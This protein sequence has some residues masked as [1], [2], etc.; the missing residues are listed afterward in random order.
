MD[1]PVYHYFQD[2]SK[3]SFGADEFLFVEL[4]ESMSLVDALRV[5]LI[6]TEVSSMKI[7]G[8]L[9]VC[10]SHISYMIRVDPNRQDPRD[11]V[12]ALHDAHARFPGAESSILETEIIEIPVYYDDPWT[13]EVL[14][15]FRQR[16]QSPTETDIAYC[17]RINGFSTIRDFISAHSGSPF[18][19]TFPCFIPGNAECFQLVP[20]K[21][22]IQ[23]PK[24][25]S[26]RT[27]TPAR[28]VGHGGAFTTV[29]PTRS[30]GGYQ[31]I[32]R[33]P[34]PVF[35]MTQTNPGFEKSI[36][37]A[38]P[39]TIFKY[40]PIDYDEYFETRASVECGQY[41]YR[42][43]PVHFNYAEFVQDIDGYN[44]RLMEELS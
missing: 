37:L 11:L 3:L 16:H 19:A 40:R 22:Q 31:L 2:G 39:G 8:I 25:V 15:K 43:S 13:T 30:P 17:A 42:R 26:P 4:S 28:A 34:V 44:A 10:P 21:R 38:Q 5:Q 36:V 6:T 35:D 20:R 32:G 27:E 1:Q 12:A 14:M 29:Y 18:I 9:D 7:P 41:H 24:Y 23:A 33:S